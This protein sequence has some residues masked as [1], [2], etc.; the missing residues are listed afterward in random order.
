MTKEEA[1]KLSGPQGAG[2]VREIPQRPYLREE[3][4]QFLRRHVMELTSNND[5]SISLR[6]ADL[7][8]RLGVSRTPVREALTRLHQE[9]IVSVQPRHGVTTLPPSLDEYLCWLEIRELMEGLAA[10]RAAQLITADGI[11]RMRSLFDQ[12][13]GDQPEKVAL[14]AAAYAEA[15][16]RFHLMLV[17]E[18]R[19]PFLLRLS[20]SYDYISAARR[21][22]TGRLD[23]VPPSMHDHSAIIDALERRDSK[24]AERLA[25]Q[26]VRQVREAVQKESEVL[27]R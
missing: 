22:F 10:R 9:G 1:L 14:T 12:F 4:Y 5:T 7:A 3:V 21:R 17:E 6:E 20:T 8:R 2:N 15:N 13:D 24:A 27:R 26:H 19:N 16:A 18:G 11:A 25:R 23:R